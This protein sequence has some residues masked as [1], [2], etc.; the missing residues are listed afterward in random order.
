MP[1]N[2]NKHTGQSSEV[3]SLLRESPPTFRAV[4]DYACDWEN[5]VGPDGRLIW[6]NEAVTRFSGY[7]VEECLAMPDYPEPLIDERDRER[8]AR[9]F[10]RALAGESGKSVEFRLRCKD[11]GVKW[12]ELSHQPIYDGRGVGIG[13]R[14]SLHDITRHKVAEERRLESEHLVQRI[15]ATTPNIIYIFD[16]VEQRPVYTNLE[17]TGILG[18]TTDQLEAMGRDW[19]ATLL[20][21][22]DV[23]AVAAH[24]ARL[25]RAE[26]GDLLE[27]E[28]RMQHVHG[29][30][31]WLNSR[32]VVFARNEDGSV[33]QILG[34]AEDITQRT[35]AEQALRESEARFRSI[36]E[37][38]PL[39]SAIVSLDQRFVRVNEATC[40]IFGYGPE[41]LIGRT[42]RDFTHPDDLQAGIEQVQRLIAGELDL[43]VAEKRHVRKDG[44]VVWG[45]LSVGIVRDASGN[46]I[47]FLPMVEDINDRK[48]AEQALQEKTEELERFL[49]LSLDLLAIT[50][51]QG[52]FRTLNPAWETTLG[53]P[54]SELVGVRFLDLVHPDDQASAREAMT[55]LAEGKSLD[56]TNR[57]RCR[58][59]GYRWIE[60]RL[61]LHGDQLIYVAARDI[62][63]RIHHE[64]DQLRMAEQLRQSQKLESVGRLAG[65][66]AHDFNN[67]L[68][69]ITGHV[70]LALVDLARDHPLRS[71]LVE[72]VTAADSAALLTRQLLAFSRK[73]ILA[74][75]ILDLNQL[76]GRMHQM[77]VRLIGEDVELRPVVQPAVGHVRADAGQME[78]ILINLAV[79]AR[80]AMP[81]GGLLT[82]ETADVFLDESYARKHPGVT[83]G[84]YVML[85]VSDTGSG[86]SPEVQQHLFEPFF[87]TKPKDKGTGLGLATVYGAVQQ[88]GGSIQ[89]ESDVGHGTSFRI[90]LP[91][92]EASTHSIPLELG[93]GA[94]P[95]GT[96]T[97][98]LVE[99]EPIVM[100]LA[101]LVLIRLGY[102]VLSAPSAVDAVQ[103]ARTHQGEIHLLMTDVVMPQM[104]GRMVA[105]QI[106]KLRPR[107]RV[108][109]TSGY[110]EDVIQHHGVLEEGIHFIGKPYTT[111][112][113]AAKLREALA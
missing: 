81:D 90:Y 47:C 87:T 35:Q 103:M 10:A 30:W 42:F 29:D 72:I 59:G 111:E 46:P 95:S 84:P 45:R 54:T 100:R 3:E 38:S 15:L 53:Y 25:T 62:T 63:D 11:G 70:S 71:T 18:Y 39:G 93:P 24:R 61:A 77:L 20:H 37:Q 56:L 48:L 112:A 68:T 28:F 69:C 44:R 99:D 31:R 104:N 12:V 64:Q 55:D 97:V 88:A 101:E 40:R 16:L 92:V 21:P 108:L 102:T 80:D 36:F 76:V 2:Q 109:Y 8:M 75:R 33:R 66:I 98:L 110:T 41:E 14:S 17:L 105:E 58:W 89:V 5:W 57:L 26:D 50:D 49:T 60:W 13:Y 107:I 43:Y 32:D 1:S 86:M 7:S 82:I 79:N 22:E 4:A 23:A 91:R 9:C 74:P 78:Q 96:E 106:Q 85:A 27:I 94:V 83:S 73:Q 113:L 34:S 65:G 6:V 52:R 51:R 19:F 67:L